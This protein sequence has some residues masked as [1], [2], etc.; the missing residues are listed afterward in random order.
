MR[1]EIPLHANAAAAGMTIAADV[2]S[3]P[4]MHE[5]KIGWARTA[6]AIALVLAVLA[7]S[8]PHAVRAAGGDAGPEWTPLGHGVEHRALAH[9]AI[10]GHAFRFRPADVV[11][12]IVPAGEGLARIPALAPEGD[13]IATNASFF[14][15]SNHAMGAAQD[16]G[17]SVGGAPLTRWAA[18]VVDGGRARI[19]RG[20]ELGKGAHDFAVQG[21]PRLVIAGEVPPL[22]PQSARRTA[23]CVDGDAMILAATRSRV[24]GAEFARFLAAGARD[25]GLGCDD[26][27][28]LDGGSSTQLLARWN[29]FEAAIEG[30]SA[31]PNALVIRPKPR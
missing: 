29:G 26:A 31:V 24:D 3:L 27:L 6:R 8:W 2:T 1:S 12:G 19:V 25:G 7:A 28:N 9:G 10:D 23:L 4:C 20:A 30:V 13:V 15:T 14:D 17:R 22:K 18:F 11:L 16:H 5:T 21:L